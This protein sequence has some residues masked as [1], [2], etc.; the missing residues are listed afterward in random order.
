MRRNQLEQIKEF[1]EI[2]VMDSK[3]RM[4]LAGSLL[5]GLPG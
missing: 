4:K 2:H 1:K 5:A 3:I